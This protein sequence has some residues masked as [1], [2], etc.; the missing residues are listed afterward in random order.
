MKKIIFGL[1]VVLLALSSTYYYKQYKYQHRFDKLLLCEQQSIIDNNTTFPNLL[2]VPKTKDFYEKFCKHSTIL[3]WFDKDLKLT[4][5]ANE[6]IDAINEAYDNG[7]DSQKYHLKMLKDEIKEYT[8][9]VE[10]QSIEAEANLA[11]KLDVKL[12]DAYISLF[13]DSYYGLTDWKKYKKIQ[14]EYNKEITQKS[15]EERRLKLIELN[16]SVED[17]EDE[18]LPKFEWEKPNKK[19]RNSVD[20]L[21]NNLKNNQIFNSLSNLHPDIKEYKKLVLILKELRSSPNPNYKK[22][23]KILL[24]MERFRWVIG[25][26]DKSNKAIVVNIPSFTLHMLEN[27]ERTWDMRVIVGKPK[28][29]TPILEGSLSYAILNPYW[30]APPTIIKEDMM[31]KADKMDEYLKAHNM[32]LFRVEKDNKIPV[33]ASDI[34]WTVYKDAKRIP[35][36]FRAEPGEDNPLGVIKF[37]FPNKY[38]VYMHDTDKRQFFAEPYRAFSSG[39]VRL[40]QPTKLFSNLLGTTEDV[41]LSSYNKQNKAEVPVSLKKEVPVVFRY[42]TAGVN[43]NG[44]LEIYDDIYGYD[45]NN[46]K[47]IKGYK[48]I[49]DINFISSP[50]F[51]VK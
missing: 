15:Q 48:N 24:N 18:P 27:G 10:F 39:C 12:T 31:K 1:F 26:Y 3:P 40:H 20:E 50:I 49:F 22:I 9:T 32:K 36:V 29:P 6:L 51:E 16:I 46:I 45:E 43:K 5:S 34:N 30:T 44:N 19:D 2:N 35:F 14:H 25:E 4:P 42:M 7:L 23:N 47:A 11:N 38:S 28:R 8:T 33:D 17:M 37:T 13:D 21:L 41:N